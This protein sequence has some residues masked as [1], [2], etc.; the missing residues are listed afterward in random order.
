MTNVTVAQGSRSQLLRKKQSGVGVAATGNY[1]IERIT[2][3]SLNAVKDLVPSTEIRSDR[4]RYDMRHGNQSAGGQTMHELVY[5]TH[6]SFIEG[7]MFSTFSSAV[8]DNAGI[9]TIG[10]TPQYF[11]LEDGALD[12]AVYRAFYD[13]VVSRCHFAFGTGSNAMVKMELD[14]VGL[15]GGDPNSATIGGTAT[16]PNIR[17]P[18]DTF[19]GAV[20]DNSPETG[21]EMIEITSMD[22]NIDNGAAPIFG[23]GQQTGVAVEFGR[24]EVGGTLSMYYTQRSRQLMERFLREIEAYLVLNIIDPSGNT[25]EF[26]MPRVKI[27][28]SDVPLANEKSRVITMPFVA[29]KDSVIGS[30]LQIT[31][32]A[33]P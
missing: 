24:G 22:L 1:F 10:T 11:T 15:S 2:G 18:F 27:N 9:V 17:P 6:D 28:G 14:W 29:L 30:A 4:E 26:R 3:H 7:A 12:L 8:T 19:T 23:L 25:M 21:A 32:T 20:Y 33:G 5:G 16:S 13:M 31:K